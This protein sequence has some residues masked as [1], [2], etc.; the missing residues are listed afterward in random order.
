MRVSLINF[1]ATRRNYLGTV[2]VWRAPL[3]NSC[4]PRISECDLIWKL[5]LCLLGLPK[6]KYHSVGGFNN[7]MYFLTVFEV[8][9]EGVGRLGFS[10]AF[11]PGLSESP[12]DFVL[13]WPFLWW[14]FITDLS[15]VCP[16]FDFL[17]GRLD[18]LTA[19]I[20]GLLSPLFTL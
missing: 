9:D 11:L 4:L 20:Y 13:T 5:S 2:V 18:W 7:R 15:C 8:Q 14:W 19:H 12:S 17:D 3:Q 10:W 6:A 16:D 1:F